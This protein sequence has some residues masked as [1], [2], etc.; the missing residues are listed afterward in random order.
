MSSIKGND[1][2]LMQHWVIFEQLGVARKYTTR[3]MP[4]DAHSMAPI[5]IQRTEKKANR[6]PKLDR[7]LE[8]FPGQGSSY[9]QA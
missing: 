8:N 3:S 7:V 5:A 1:G 4:I 2:K 6:R 9:E